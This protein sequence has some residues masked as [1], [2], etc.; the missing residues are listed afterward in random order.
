MDPGY[1][2][3]LSEGSKALERAAAAR[4]SLQGGGTLK[5]LTRYSQGEASQE[6]QNAFNRSLQ[7]FQANQTARQQRFSNLSGL[8]GMGYNAERPADRTS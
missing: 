3:R 7:G 5:A 8:A 2:F 4:G 6:Y 1:Q